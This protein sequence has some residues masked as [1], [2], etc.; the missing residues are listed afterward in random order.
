MAN[1]SVNTNKKKSK[2]SKMKKRLILVGIG[3]FSPLL[4]LYLFLAFYYNT[5]FYNRT[6]INGIN[7]SNLTLEN[8]EELIL[9]EVNTYVLGLEGRNGINDR[10]AA[11]SMGLHTVFDGDLGDL[12][13]KQNSFLWP[14]SLVKAHDMELKAILKFDEE[15]LKAQIKNLKFF[16]EENVIPP[17]DAH[18]SEYGENG[19]EIIAEDL[20]AK[21]DENKLFE[22]MKAAILSL[23]PSLSL[24][25]A[26]AYEKPEITADSKDLSKVMNQLK[27]ITGAKITYEFGEDIEVLDGSK[28]SQWLTVD[29]DLNVQLNEAGVKEYVDYIGKTYNSFGRTRSFMT[30]YGKEVIVKGG[31]Y[32]WWLNRT[33]EVEE[34]KN[35][36]LNGE[37]LIKEP[38]YYQTAQQYGK[39]DIGNTYVEVNLT[40]QHLFFYKDGELVVDAEFV[41]GNLARNYGTPT[42]TYPIQYKE[43]D[44][45][46]N[47]E[48]YSTPVKY[49]MPF[50]GNIGFHDANWRSTFG[51]VIY[52]TSGSHG[53]INMPPA[54]AKIMFENIKRGV[55]VVVYE[56]EGTENYGKDKEDKEKEK[57][58]KEDNVNGTVDTSPAR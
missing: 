49:W 9:A 53:C 36:I 47:G 12:L 8:A 40:A 26:D 2:K 14:I 46:L 27:K 37:Q 38:V 39:D 17:V 41:S 54:K 45:I 58:T 57:T 23:Q 18:I 16:Q 5:H 51:G 24:E 32:G 19:F 52:K 20:G 35:L 11:S 33:K 56:L 13:K 42:G 48:D 15:L 3:I 6:T 28:I 4:I 30:S 50:N 7:T 44:A 10:I 55:A 29:D 1:H 22:A 25:E 31:D 21:V 34:L 43:N